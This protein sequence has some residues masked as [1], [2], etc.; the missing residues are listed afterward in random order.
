MM[1]PIQP[2]TSVCA[3]APSLWSGHAG[4]SDTNPD[5]RE[6]AEHDDEPLTEAVLV[7]RLRERSPAECNALVAGLSQERLHGLS[8]L[9]SA[10]LAF[11]EQAE[12]FDLLA[13][14]LDGDNLVRVSAAYMHS[15][16]L[17]LWADSVRR[18]ASAGSKLGL[19]RV[20]AEQMG[21]AAQPLRL[22][23]VTCVDA[24]SSGTSLMAANAFAGLAGCTKAV[25]EALQWLVPQPGETKRLQSVVEAALQMHAAVPRGSG[26]AVIASDSQPLV[27]IVAASAY[28]THPCAKAAV[29]EVSVQAFKRVAANACPTQTWAMHAANAALAQALSRLVF[30]DTT[31]ILAALE[32]HHGGGQGLVSYLIGMV[33]QRRTNELR[34]MTEQLLHGHDAWEKPCAYLARH[35]AWG[36]YR[37]AAVLGYYVGAVQVAC[38]MACGDG[39]LRVDTLAA[40][41]G[42]GLVAGPANLNQLWLSGGAARALQSI[43]N[44]PPCPGNVAL[45]PC[46]RHSLQAAGADGVAAT[47]ILRYLLQGSPWGA[48]GAERAYAAAAHRVVVAHG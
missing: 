36:R 29:F 11:S 4:W 35:D 46:L 40:I 1:H 27:G 44:A 45:E 16:A 23:A 17:G 24:A 32:A 9:A 38:Q 18:H 26:Q 42:G 47:Q 21:A 25:D 37:H 28:G 8:A 10:G 48:S 7:Q 12:L 5:R 41:F 43:A 30:S 2:V 13:S 3:L 14:C 19:I 22:G 6:S 20:W 31:G 15:A 33:Q 34:V 39:G